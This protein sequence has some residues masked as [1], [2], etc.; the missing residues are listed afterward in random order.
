MFS[1]TCLFIYFL[2]KQLGNQRVHQGHVEY[3]LQIKPFILLILSDSSERNSRHL[4]STTANIRVTRCGIGVP[5]LDLFMLKLGLRLLLHRFQLIE[6]GFVADF[7]DFSG[8]AT[9]P[10]GL[11]QHSLNGF[12][13]CLHRCTTA[14]LQ[15]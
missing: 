10:A 7:E 6:K 5:T 15:Q 9:V 13:L 4:G 14:N 11:R 12:T 8:L 2:Y 3:R 1:F